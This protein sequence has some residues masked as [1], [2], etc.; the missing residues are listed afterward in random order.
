MIS[1]IRHFS[2]TDEISNSETAD[3]A[4]RKLERTTIELADVFRDSI[5][6]AMNSNTRIGATQML[7]G[8][9]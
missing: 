4:R 9:E 2:N 7:S 8:S 3:S 5:D 6:I 1:E